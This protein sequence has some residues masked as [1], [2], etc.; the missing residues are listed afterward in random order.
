MQ[1]HGLKIILLAVLI[2]SCERDNKSDCNN[3][4]CTQEFKTISVLIKHISDSSAVIL[5][6]FKVIRVSDN[7]DISHGN[8][9]IPENYGYYPLVDDS[10]KEMLRNSNVEI[11]F[12]GYLENSL[13]IKK[14]L[15]VTADCCHVSLVSGETTVYI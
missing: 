6:T 8:S 11:E 4:F 10:N 14:Q 2:L 12:Q 15:V 5:T 7:K 3:V 13:V 1:S 9:I